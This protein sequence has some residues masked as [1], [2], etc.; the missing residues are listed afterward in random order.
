M[1]YLIF[2]VFLLCPFIVYGQEVPQVSITQP[3]NGTVFD[4]GQIKVDY[5]VVGAEPKS[6]KGT[7]KNYHL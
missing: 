3:I 1:K 2:F 5:I 7:P 6:V 4:G